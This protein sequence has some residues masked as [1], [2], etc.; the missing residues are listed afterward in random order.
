VCA[1]KSFCLQAIQ[2]DIEQIY[3][4]RLEVALHRLQL[5]TQL[6]TKPERTEDAA[7]LII[8]QVSNAFQL[9][10]RPRRRSCVYSS[11]ICRENRPTFLMA[12]FCQ[13][14]SNMFDFCRLTFRKYGAVVD[15][16][17]KHS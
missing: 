9:F 17:N 13:L 15:W 5:R 7:A 4:S 1:D 8:E 11:V 2:F 3:K 10:S 16:V 12:D 14:T 6:Y